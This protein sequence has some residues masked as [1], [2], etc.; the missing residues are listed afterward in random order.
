MEELRLKRI[1]AAMRTLLNFTAREEAKADRDSFA[2]GLARDLTEEERLHLLR[3]LVETFPPDMAERA[4]LATFEDNGWPITGL[5]G[6]AAS[7]AKFWADT[8]S[9]AELRAYGA[10]CYRRMSEKGKANFREWVAK[11]AKKDG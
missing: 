4:V 11:D 9:A 3:L 1:T 5:H 10:A 8:A 7:D 2:L 6:D